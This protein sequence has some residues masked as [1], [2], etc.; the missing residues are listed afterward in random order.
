MDTRNHPDL[1]F[2][3]N[4][5][6]SCRR[7]HYPAPGWSCISVRHQAAGCSSAWQWMSQ[8]SQRRWTWDDLKNVIFPGG[9]RNSNKKKK[10][11]GEDMMSKSIS[12][13]QGSACFSASSDIHKQLF[14]SSYQLLNATCSLLPCLSGPDA[15]GRETHL[16]LTLH[17][18]SSHCSRLSAV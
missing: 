11:T 1:P 13:L 5:K 15:D 16:S 8:S 4:L 9:E 2:R 12:A 14:V 7:I 17:F 10:K 18:K 3:R 6:G